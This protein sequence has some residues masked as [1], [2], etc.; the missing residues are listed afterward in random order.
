VSVSVSVLLFV[1]CGKEARLGE[2]GLTVPDSSEEAFTPFTCSVDY[3]LVRSGSLLVDAKI[4]V[5]V[6]VTKLHDKDVELLF[7]LYWQRSA[8]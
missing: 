1:V 5:Q 8:V 4:A 2:R 3:W 6:I 7:G